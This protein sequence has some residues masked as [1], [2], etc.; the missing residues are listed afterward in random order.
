M[1]SFPRGLCVGIYATNSAE[2]CQYV[3]THAKVNILLVENDL[4]L[5]K[6]LS[7]RPK[8]KHCPP[9]TQGDCK[10]L[11]TCPV[12]ARWMPMIVGV[13]GLAPL[14]GSVSLLHG[15]FGITRGRRV[16]RQG[17]NFQFILTSFPTELFFSMPFI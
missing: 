3:I 4:Q 8:R 17:S 11:T 15:Y 12:A 5:K 7:V 13:V 9:V 1:F 14:L 6:I 10:G 16:E 2:A